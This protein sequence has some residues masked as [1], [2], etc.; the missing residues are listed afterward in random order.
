MT[1]KPFKGNIYGWK[2]TI[3]DT[4]NSGAESD[5][6]IFGFRHKTLRKLG[7]SWSTSKVINYNKETG[8]VKT[9]N[10]RYKLIGNEE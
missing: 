10:S 3:Y 1:A 2:R 5:Y 7:T 8:E 4:S 9:L 6:Y